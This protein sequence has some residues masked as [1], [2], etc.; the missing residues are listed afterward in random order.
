[1]GCDIHGWVEE[2]KDDNWIAILPLENDRRNYER[3]NKLAGVRGD[4]DK[5]PLGIPDDI[6]DTAKY[7][8]DS[9]GR[10]GHSH[11]YMNLQKALLIFVETESGDGVEA[12]FPM[13]DHFGIEDE[14]VGYS[15]SDRELRL[16]FWF[17]N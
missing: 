2:K 4:S 13:S 6:S 3:F 5:H 14:I 7:W 10:D 15:S 17:D 8:I 9:W 11:S 16:I 1:M 12:E